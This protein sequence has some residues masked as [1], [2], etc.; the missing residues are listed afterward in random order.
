[1][2]IMNENTY[3]FYKHSKLY[4]YILNDILTFSFK[5]HEKLYDETSYYE[6][7]YDETS[8]YET[9]Y[10]ET[11]YYDDNLYGD[12]NDWEDYWDSIYNE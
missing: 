11:P 2:N 10:D 3:Y 5:P 4:K 1:M 12:Y 7:S 9:S 8:Y 6:K